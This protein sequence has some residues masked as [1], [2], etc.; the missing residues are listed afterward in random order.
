[1]PP[2]A[3]SAEDDE[4]PRLGPLLDPERRLEG[5]FSGSDGN[6]LD[7]AKLNDG[8]LFNEGGGG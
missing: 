1:M 3:L 4:S 8:L 7:G 6:G 2:S 5:R